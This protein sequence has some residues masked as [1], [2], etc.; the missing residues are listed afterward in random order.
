MLD[1]LMLDGHGHHPGC[2]QH[3]K[4]V[5]PTLG[6]SGGSHLDYFCDCHNFKEPLILK[7]GTDIAWPL[8]W[9]QE[10]AA[11]WREKNGLARP[12]EPGSGP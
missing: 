5:A 2:P 9:Q 3:G 6:E 11:D 4:D 12:S 7:N 10:Q 8:G 1:A